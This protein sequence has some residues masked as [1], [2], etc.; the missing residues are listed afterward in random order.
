MKKF[1]LAVS[2]FMLAGCA[3]VVGKPSP[4]MEVGDAEFIKDCRLMETF[5]GPMGYRMWGP[6]YIGNFK[7]E[8]MEK[9]EKMGATH[10]LLRTDVDGIGSTGIINV[11]QC[12]PDHD[13][14]LDDDEY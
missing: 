4:V 2:L 13:L 11:Y 1:G 12:P 8:V 9:A 3:G 5:T 10:M 14:L 6:P 7:K